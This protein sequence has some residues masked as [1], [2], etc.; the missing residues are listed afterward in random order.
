MMK[1]KAGYLVEI[2]IIVILLLPSICFG[3]RIKE[4]SSLPIEKT[5][6]IYGQA[7]GNII[8]QK[9]DRLVL[10]NRRHQIKSEVVLDSSQSTVV[11]ANGMFYGIVNGHKSE[12][13]VSINSTATIYSNRGVP[14]WSVYDLVEGDYYLAASGD[15][16]IAITGTTGWFN[17]KMFLYYKNRS[18]IEVDIQSFENLFFSE[19]GD[20]LLIDAGAKGVKL[21]S[22]DGD[23]LQQ[24]D[25]Q[26]MIAFSETGKK[27]VAYSHKGVLKI[28]EGNNDKLTLELKRLSIEG[29]ILRDEINT[30]LIIYNN[31]IVVI[32]AGDGSVLWDYG[33]GKEG[34]LFASLDVSPNN[35]FIA[36]GID[37]NKG[38]AAEKSERHELGYL[39]VYDI[40]GQ[41]L[42]ELK[43]QYDLYSKGLPDV[44]FLSDNRTISVRNAES[45]HFVEIY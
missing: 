19:D 13:S 17:Y 5:D 28:F 9:D 44:K 20:F 30:V 27:F 11:A 3:F 2:I 18:V 23:F 10:L 43:F 21:Y 31:R 29:F 37:V 22:A 16:L 12:D 36:C 33:S 40:E 15:Y 25:S 14:L 7:T 41:D 8:I 42:Q 6:I 26:K 4:V 35:K 34:G 38:K 24:Y 1:Y 39:F 32:N 45:L